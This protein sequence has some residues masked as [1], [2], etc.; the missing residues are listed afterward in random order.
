MWQLRFEIALRQT[1]TLLDTAQDVEARNRPRYALALNP[2]QQGLVVKGL[3]QPDNG[4]IKLP[5]AV[6]EP[7]HMI[8]ERVLK[9]CRIL[10]RFE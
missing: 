7:A 4:A 1:I 8:N 9:A 2:G 6:A 3:V 10:G 5:I